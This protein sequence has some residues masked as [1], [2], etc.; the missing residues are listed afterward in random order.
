VVGVGG[1]SRRDSG[2]GEGRRTAVVWGSEGKC[3]CGSDPWLSEIRV[4]TPWIIRQATACFLLRVLTAA[5]IELSLLSATPPSVLVVKLSSSGD[6]AMTPGG[7]W[8]IGVSCP[9]TWLVSAGMPWKPNAA[10]ADLRGFLV[11]VL[12][13]LGSGEGT[14]GGAGLAPVMR[15]RSSMIFK[16]RYAP[17]SL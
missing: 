1:G 17:L 11:F 4:S 14:T 12:A 13:G 9:A 16:T 6:D 3:G 15:R 5:E 10:G 2:T 7:I 8:R